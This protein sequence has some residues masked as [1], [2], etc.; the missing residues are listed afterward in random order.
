MHDPWVVGEDPPEWVR[1][2]TRREC[3]PEAAMHKWTTSLR[4]LGVARVH[5]TEIPNPAIDLDHVAEANVRRVRR[6]LDDALIEAVEDLLEKRK[7][8]RRAKKKQRA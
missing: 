6:P 4:R 1:S 8:V 3:W 2:M 5:F 7:L